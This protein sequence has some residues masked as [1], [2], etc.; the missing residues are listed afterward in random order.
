MVRNV[1]GGEYQ[2]FINLHLNTGNNITI[3][4]M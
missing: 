4:L 3:T 1:I 2:H